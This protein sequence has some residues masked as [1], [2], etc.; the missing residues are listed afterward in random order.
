MNSGAARE[1]ILQRKVARAARI[2]SAV[3]GLLP[4]TEQPAPH[5]RRFQLLEIR[6][7]VSRESFP[8]LQSMACYGTGATL[9]LDDLEPHAQQLLEDYELTARSLEMRI[10]VQV[11]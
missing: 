8:M 5:A 1:W 3:S 9:K 7:Y 6:G 4:E 11:V 10:P 2:L